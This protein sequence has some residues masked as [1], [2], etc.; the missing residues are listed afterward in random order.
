MATTII[1]DDVDRIAYVQSGFD[2]MLLQH[3]HAYTDQAGRL[4]G[5]N[6]PRTLRSYFMGYPVF[7]ATEEIWGRLCLLEGTHGVE[8]HTLP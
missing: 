2:L 7:V 4:V 3:K 8:A 6:D 1:A 5:Y